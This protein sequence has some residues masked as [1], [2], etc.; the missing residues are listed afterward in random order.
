MPLF[1]SK[2]LKSYIPC[3][4]QFVINNLCLLMKKVLLDL[5]VLKHINCG[6]GQVAYNYG[7]YFSN[8]T[9]DDLEITLL[10]P[11]K[12]FGAFGSNVKYLE[13]K[14]IY[15]IFPCLIPQ[16]DVWHSIHQLSRFSPSRKATKNI[17]TIHDL[18]FLY[19]KEAD[20]IE[21]YRKKIAKK[22]DRADIITV[23]S[24]F[25]KNDVCKNFEIKKSIEVIYNGVEFLTSDGEQKPKSVNDSTPFIF[26]I[27]QMFPKK[28]FH[29]LLDAMKLLPQFNLY[30]VG[31]KT[32]EYGQMIENRIK[33]ENIKNVFL[34]GEIEH[35]E[36]IWMY[37]HC[38]AFV[39]PSLFE[40]FGLPII[41]AMFF[42]KPVISSDKTS[43][44]E[45]G[46]DQVEFL[47]NFSPDEIAQKIL[48]AIEKAKKFPETLDMKFRYASSFSYQKHFEEYL[49]L[50]RTI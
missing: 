7:V 26:S 12:Y 3:D 30:L 20:K 33:G 35:I 43:L 40:G 23:I 48:L 32:T 4:F 46:A 10:L 25:V 44:R 39:F 38:E 47:D 34:L 5:S 9:F 45:I 17:L 31:K 15:T 14:E 42:R 16:F 21:K 6:L 19:E 29:V 22:I 11:K 13:S 50:Y 41:E 18:N 28:N 1:V 37:N 24:N 27:G 2:R 8:H 49:K 36:K